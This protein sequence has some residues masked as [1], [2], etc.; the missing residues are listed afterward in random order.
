MFKNLTISKKIISGFSLVIILLIIVSYLS[1]GGVSKIVDEINY[2]VFVNSI[3]GQLIE[4]KAAHLNWIN[5]LSGLLTNKQ[6]TNLD[7]ETNPEKCHFGKWLNSNEKRKAEEIFPKL[8]PILKE[9]TVYHKKLHD[10]GREIIENFEQADPFLPQLI[11]SKIADHLKWANELQMVFIHEKDDLSVETNPEKCAFGVWLKSDQAK[12]MYENGDKDLKQAFDDVVNIHEKLHKSA[13]DIKNNL[14]FEKIK[15]YEIQKEKIN[16]TFEKIAGLF[17]KVLLDVMEKII[18]PAKKNAENSGNMSELVKWSNIDMI[19]NEQII[20]KFL[21]L[22]LESKED[23]FN[24]Q[25]YNKKINELKANIQL[26]VNMFQGSNQLNR[27]INDINTLLV[28]WDNISRQLFKIIDQERNSKQ[29]LN[30]ARE[31]FSQTTLPLLKTTMDKL[32]ILL[33]EAVHEIE[34][35][36][37][38]SQK[39]NQQVQ[40]VFAKMEILFN[41]SLKLIEQRIDESNKHIRKTGKS[42]EQNVI[43]IAVIA[44]A[45]GIICAI[46]IVLSVVYPIKNVNTMLKDIAQ[47][48]GDLTSRLVINNKDELGELAKWF[49]LFIEK[50]QKIIKDFSNTTNTLYTSSEKISKISENL[51]NSAETSSQKSN[52]VA[53]A[54]EEMSSNMSTVSAST[55]Q[56]SSNVNM[57]ASAAEEMT[58]T[59]SEIS[60]NSEKARSVTENAVNKAHN[61]SLKVNELGNS[62]KEIGTVTETITDI[63]EQTNLLALNA[64]IEAARAGEAGKGFAVVAN[65]IKE[66]AKQTAAA[67]EQIKNQIDGIQNTTSSSVVEIEEITKVIKDVNE[68]VT[69]I[70]AAIEEQTVVTKDIAANVAQAS[71]GIAEVLQNVMHT[72]EVSK[73]IAGNIA[74]VNDLNSGCS[75]NSLELNTSSQE[76]RS[77][78]ENLKK[79]VNQFK[80]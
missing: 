22:W 71:N 45:I 77:L 26:W 78:S 6:V 52:N 62:A 74:E 43:I 36:N 50:I 4:A 41:K 8:A 66:L 33:E 57:V 35:M 68:I 60:Q 67:T 49:N 42:T 20:Q 56:T 3:E 18:D 51:C 58:S 61:A 73:E 46:V 59:I 24:E 12:K 48:E 31:I 72:T 32:K 16:K 70:A 44:I 15:S 76:L 2:V 23:T 30:K 37:Q 54:A 14:V 47:G 7:I 5:K 69:S 27:S 10:F 40:P 53:V 11:E 9:M 1:V 75:S 39:F 34:S 28:N 19:M 13:I 38:S 63:S 29:M 25:L 21:H 17:S 55:E 80:F 79:L 64:T 65:E